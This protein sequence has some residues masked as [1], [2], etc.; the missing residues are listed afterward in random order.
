MYLRSSDFLLSK[1]FFLTKK[2]VFCWKINIFSFCENIK[3][4]VV[5]DKSVGYQYHRNR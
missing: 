5:I 4:A 2:T 1:K 3:N